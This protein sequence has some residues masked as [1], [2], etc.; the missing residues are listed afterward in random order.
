MN[1][2]ILPTGKLPPGLLKRILA[3]APQLD[4]R[5]LLGPGIGLDCAVLDL[6]TQLLVIKSDPI[7]FTS[8]SIGWYVVQISA[9]D[10]ATCGGVPRW[11]LLTALLPEGHTDEE[12]ALRISQEAFDACR[13]LN[14]SVI[15]GHTEITH[16]LD[17][18]IL[19]GTLIG[20]VERSAL[21]TPRGALPGDAILLTK[22]VPIEG[23]AI[24]AREFPDRLIPGWKR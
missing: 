15:G 1:A 18:P 21:V 4:S 7:T 24:L 22:G 20:E 6:G 17:R 5:V 13:A 14:I 19:V 23:T 16:G 9:N 8:D 11:M 3:M 12:L 10:I 2:Q